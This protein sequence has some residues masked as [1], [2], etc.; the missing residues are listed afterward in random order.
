MTEKTLSE[1]SILLLTEDAESI[2]SLTACLREDGFAIACSSLREFRAE[3]L[4][5]ENW[6][7]LLLDVRVP[8]LDGITLCHET[9]SRFRGPIM[10]LATC[11]DEMFQIL[12]LELGA[13][14]F[15]C[16]PVNPPL[17]LARVRAL[18]RRKKLTEGGN[19]RA[20]VQGALAI[21]AGRREVKLEGKTVCFTS[22]EFD[23]LHY[24]AG[25]AGKIVSRDAIHRFL[26]N[27]EYN[28]YD[29]SIDIYVSRIRQ[30]LG[31]DPFEP[32]YLKTVRGAGYLFAG[33][34]A[35]QG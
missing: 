15:L 27:A 18:L 24:L 13:D 9:R 17:F 20:I 21:D 30:K 28:G 29:R 22:R 26:Y 31:D 33:N 1:K 25:H 7:M 19:G 34:S 14:D 4:G 11:E 35:W 2:A 5:D 6:V 16:K 12:G 23:L 8:P 32:R 3:A 10:L